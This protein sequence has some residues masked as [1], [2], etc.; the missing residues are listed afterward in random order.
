MS[1]LLD[2]PLLVASGAAIEAVTDDEHA[3]DR[4]AAATMAGFMA[5]SIP[6]WLDKDW[7]VLEAFW[8]P[9]GSDGPRDFMINS[10]VLSLPVPRKA[11]PRHHLAAAAIFLTYPMFL[12]AGRRLVRRRKVRRALAEAS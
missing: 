6:L 7:K 1:F 9:F 10:G 5:A 3:A 2:P 12:R 11:E 4:L 8:R